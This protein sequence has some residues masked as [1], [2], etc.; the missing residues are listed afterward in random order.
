VK[1]F[2]SFCC[3]QDSLPS[4]VAKLRVLCDP[5]QAGDAA[6]QASAKGRFDL[7]LDLLLAEAWPQRRSV[8]IAAVSTSPAAVAQG[9]PSFGN[10]APSN[11][12]SMGGYSPV[13]SPVV[14][15]NLAPPEP[16]KAAQAA[17]FCS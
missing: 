7:Q 4:A 11:T 12:I 8:E 6:A 17:L 16:A 10:Y 3:N 13:F 2:L 15:V 5:P 14:N 9:A 1:S